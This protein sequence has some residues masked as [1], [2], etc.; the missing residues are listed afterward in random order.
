MAVDHVMTEQLE[1]DDL[2]VV[3]GP[4]HMRG[5]SRPWSR[6]RLHAQEPGT[7]GEVAAGV[8]ES[9][10]GPTPEPD[11][12][13]GAQSGRWSHDVTGQGRAQWSGRA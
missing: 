10:K 2:I 12:R 6:E 9:L 5:M 8:R 3:G 1:R 11:G 7:G 4:T 13:G